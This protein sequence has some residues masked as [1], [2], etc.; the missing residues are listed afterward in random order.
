MSGELK[1]WAGMSCMGEVKIKKKFK[2]E[3]R[4]EAAKYD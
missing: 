4:G 2:E 1:R 3:D